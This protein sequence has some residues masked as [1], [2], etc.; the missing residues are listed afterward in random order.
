VTPFER[1]DMPYV[2]AAG[3]AVILIIILIAAYYA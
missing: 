3:I 2:I 1:K